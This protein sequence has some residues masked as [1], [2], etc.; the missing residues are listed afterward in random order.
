[1]ESIKTTS[2]FGNI[3]AVRENGMS[4]VSVTYTLF[5]S[6]FQIDSRFIYSIR[7]VTRSEQGTDTVSARDIC[8]ERSEA[9]RLL[10]LLAD[11]MVTACTLF[12]ILDDIL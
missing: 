9:I 1:M 12:D 4:G 2:E 7:L 8:R 5:E 10:D 11:G 6:D 3:L